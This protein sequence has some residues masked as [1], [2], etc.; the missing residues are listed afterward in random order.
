VSGT[1]ILRQYDCITYAAYG[2]KGETRFP[3]E[4][5]TAG[6][7][8]IILQHGINDIIHPVGTEVNVFRPWSDMPTLEEMCEGFTK[9]YIEPAKAMNLKV[10][11]GTLLPIYGWRTYA[12]F[13]ETLKN[14]FN[15]WLRSL[16]IDSTLDGCVDFDMAV[17][18]ENFPERFR[19]GFDSGDH[20]HPSKAAYKAMA[21]AVPNE[22]LNY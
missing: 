18:D 16:A 12:D 22:L 15:D 5:N 21:A 13:R 9:L 4:V 1:R 8:A 19:E 17:R 7:D 20:L 3:I 6:A 2:L 10:W 11:G 14:Q